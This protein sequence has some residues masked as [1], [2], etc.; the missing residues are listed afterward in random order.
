MKSPPLN[1]RAICRLGQGAGHFLVLSGVDKWYALA[2]LDASGKVVEYLPYS[3]SYPSYDL[4]ISANRNIVA[5][6]EGDQ[7]FIQRR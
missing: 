6:V 3:F 4:T 7:V 5:V 2:R 1:C